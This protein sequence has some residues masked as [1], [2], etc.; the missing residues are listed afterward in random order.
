MLPPPGCPKRL[1]DVTGGLVDLFPGSSGAETA[2][3]YSQSSTVGWA[4]G[5]NRVAD[6]G[7]A[8]EEEGFVQARRHAGEEAETTLATGPGLGGLQVPAGPVYEWPAPPVASG[9]Q[10]EFGR[11]ASPPQRWSG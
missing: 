3:L 5:R 7:C 10:E 1:R 2:S 9:D 11:P 6:A 4:G 8:P